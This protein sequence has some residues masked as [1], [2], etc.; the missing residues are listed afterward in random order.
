MTKLTAVDPEID[1]PEP[2][3]VRHF[4]EEPP[5]EP[6]CVERKVAHQAQSDRAVGVKRA[7]SML[8]QHRL[9]IQG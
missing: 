8:R 7:T 1:D 6:D 2:R 9:S 5:L 3:D 4:S